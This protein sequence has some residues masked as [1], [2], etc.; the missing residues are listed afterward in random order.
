MSQPPAGGG[1]RGVSQ[2][3]F[4]PTLTPMHSLQQQQV[5][6][7]SGNGVPTAIATPAFGQTQA[8]TVMPSVSA[9]QQPIPS[10]DLYLCN[11]SNT[12]TGK[13]DH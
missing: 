4:I 8:A 11:T 13:S 6:I 2:P 10:A 1:Q 12:A 7:T 5:V 3:F 9:L